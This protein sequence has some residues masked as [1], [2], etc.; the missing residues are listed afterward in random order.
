L[1]K[2]PFVVRICENGVPQLLKKGTSTNENNIDQMRS[3]KFL[4]KNITTDEDV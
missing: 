1:A 2:H 4:L 3:E